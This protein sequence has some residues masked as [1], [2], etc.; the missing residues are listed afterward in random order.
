[1]SIAEFFIK[2]GISVLAGTA[3]FIFTYLANMVVGIATALRILRSMRHLN[4]S[5]MT[6]LCKI[7]EDLNNKSRMFHGF[8]LWWKARKYL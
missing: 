6:E 3:L 7:M 4:E 2:L 5:E 1:M 8:W